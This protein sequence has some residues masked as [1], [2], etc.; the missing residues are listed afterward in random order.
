[1]VYRCIQTRL[2]KVARKEIMIHK[3]GLER[4]TP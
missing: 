2:Y 1:M 4:E 3:V